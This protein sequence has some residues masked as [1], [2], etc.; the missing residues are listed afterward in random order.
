MLLDAATLL[1]AGRDDVQILLVGDGPLRVELETAVRQR[2][3]Q[4][5]IHFAGRRQDVSS[6][7]KSADCLVL[8]SRWEGMPN[9]VLE[10]MAAG[11]P[12][13][14]TDVDGIGDLIETGET[15]LLVPSQKPQSLAE[16]IQTVL[17]DPER[18]AEM[19]CAAQHVT[20]KHFT[21][22]SSV[23]KYDRLYTELIET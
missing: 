5:R 21:W 9:V 3:Q 7:M 13:V 2:D 11:L 14:A 12:V 16:A 15:G 6:L 1:F 8:P 23:D 20:Q 22:K 18:T 17:N 10:A 19:I 4:A